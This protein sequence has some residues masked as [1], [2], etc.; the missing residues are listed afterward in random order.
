MFNI[1][2]HY[3]GFFITSVGLEIKVKHEF[4]FDMYFSFVSVKNH[5]LLADNEISAKHMNISEVTT[6][7]IEKI[8]YLCQ[9]CH[10]L[11]LNC[12]RVEIG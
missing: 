4:G 10:D 9:R 6:S 8:S 12:Q 5:F 7:K 3:T 2:S 11:K 1:N